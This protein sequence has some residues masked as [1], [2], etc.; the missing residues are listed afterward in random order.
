MP[1]PHEGLVATQ[2]PDLLKRWPETTQ[3]PSIARFD[4]HKAVQRE[5]WWVEAQCVELLT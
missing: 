2:L 4:P 3:K 5:R 1:L